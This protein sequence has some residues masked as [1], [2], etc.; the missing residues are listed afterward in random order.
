MAGND[1]ERGFVEITAEIGHEAM[2]AVTDFLISLGAGGVAF[3]DEGTCRVT[4]Y[5]RPEE[6]GRV[7]AALRSRL[8]EMPSFGLDPGPARITTRFVADADWAHA[9]RAHYHVTRVSE[10]IV[11]R[12]VWEAYTPAPGD[13]V[14]DMDP[15]MAFGTGTHET[16]ALCLAALDELVR[17]GIRVADIGT[18]SGILA[19]AAAKLGAAW[20]DAV[21]IDPEAADAAR[22][23]A[24]ANGVAGRV[25]V[26]LGDAGTLARAGAPPYDLIV[27]N[28]VADVIIRELPRLAALAGRG[29]VLVLSGIIDARQDDVARALAAGG[30]TGA[31]WQQR[32]EWLSVRVRR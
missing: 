8:A 19:I 2:E 28:I 26:F 30:W 11:V 7:V 21:D 12:P 10:R 27:M 14:I 3:T 25:R 5:F 23:N 13:V 6:A 24:A 15:G 22:R 18:G 1:R 4:A 32:G 17:P 29:A 31:V 9:W 16:T 20:V